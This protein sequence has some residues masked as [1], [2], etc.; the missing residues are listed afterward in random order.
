MICVVGKLLHSSSTWWATVVQYK[1]FKKSQELRP[2]LTTAVQ[3]AKF[4]Y[5]DTVSSL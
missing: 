5:C 1:D 2:L 3:T 4:S